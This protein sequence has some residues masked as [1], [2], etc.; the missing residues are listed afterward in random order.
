MVIIMKIDELLDMIDETLEESAG[1]P[2]SGGKRMVDVDRV[3]EL[4][5]DIRINMP[6]E[7]RK[8]K[9]IVEDR[10]SIIAQANNEAATIIKRA[11]EHV[12][13]LVSQQ[14]VVKAADIQAKD[15]IKTARDDA[16]ET[17]IKMTK[18][19]D[20]MLNK[21]QDQMNKSA[22]ELKTLRDEL[23]KKIAKK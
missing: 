21:T 7:I 11:G 23:N 8:A 10:G 13:K 6:A 2:F 18:Y 12:R 15:I 1:V 4:L 22:L 9:D 5:E 20:N 3:R 17:V 16:N 14:E 19:C